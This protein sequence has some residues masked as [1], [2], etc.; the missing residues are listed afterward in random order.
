[1][2]T[3]LINPANWWMPLS[4]VVSGRE[5]IMSGAVAASRPEPGSTTW[6]AANW[7]ST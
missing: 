6:L 7:P 3:S 5:P 4:G 1:M 2:A